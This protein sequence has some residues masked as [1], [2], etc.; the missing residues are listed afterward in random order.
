VGREIAGCDICQDVC[1]W[2]RRAATSA[3]SAWQPR[4]GLQGSTLLDFARLSDDDWRSHLEGSA[5][6][7]AG[8]GR[9]RRSLA[10][11]A[12]ALPPGDRALAL[13]ALSAHP[14]AADPLVAAA[15]AWARAEPP[16]AG[17]A[18]DADDDRPGVR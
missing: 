7:R 8:L 2:N 12:A 10:L 13:E 9:L 17:P 18:A 15:L 3:D 6:R 16:A 1:P 5:L 11:A 14:S 4:D